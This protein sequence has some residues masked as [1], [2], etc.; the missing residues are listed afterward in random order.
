M[1]K[2]K[3]KV[4]HQLGTTWNNHLF[5]KILDCLTFWVLIQTRCDI[6]LLK[7]LLLGITET[8]ITLVDRIHFWVSAVKRN[9][10]KM[11]G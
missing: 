7:C 3:K 1:L 8:C 10:A 9:Y 11:F 4:A 5:L 6:I 2:H